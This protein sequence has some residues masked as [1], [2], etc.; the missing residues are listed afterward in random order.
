MIH[1]AIDGPAGS[2]KSTI[3]KKVA[4]K[5]NIKYLDSGALYRIIG[6]FFK[7]KLNTFDENAIRENLED[8]KISLENNNYILNNEKIDHQIRKAESGNYASIVAKIP[9]VRNKVNDILRNIS[10][11]MSTVIDGRDIGTVVL[12]NAEYKFFL[13]ASAQERATRRYNEL[14][15]KGEKV[16]YNSIL[17]EIQQRDYNDS[18]R[19]I[20]PLQPAEDA[21][22]IDTTSK[23]IDQVLKEILNHIDGDFYESKNS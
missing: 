19:K 9:E 12:P 18:N 16:D 2:G 15:K 4:N 1:V 17:E 22:E 10:D 13:T 5:L 21:I 11:K 3:A 23:N 20:A 6:Y 7:E 14:I 8:I